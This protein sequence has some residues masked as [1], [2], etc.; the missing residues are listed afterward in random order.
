MAGRAGPQKD[1][2][3]R[4]HAIKQLALGPATTGGGMYQ[5]PF[6]FDAGNHPQP[7]DRRRNL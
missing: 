6:N 4:H 1:P 2:L 3:R 5:P 7:V